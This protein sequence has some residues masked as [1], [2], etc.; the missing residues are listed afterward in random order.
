[1]TDSCVQEWK[2]ESDC[3]PEKGTLQPP[4][5]PPPL[6]LLLPSPPWSRAQTACRVLLALQAATV[7]ICTSRPTRSVVQSPVERE[8]GLELGPHYILCRPTE[9]G[10]PFRMILFRALSRLWVALCLYTS[11]A[12]YIVQPSD[13]QDGLAEHIHQVATLTMLAMQRLC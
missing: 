3:R 13:R 4:S 8:G 10:G 1:M 7:H 5:L 9:R 2:G 12:S 6:C 11:T